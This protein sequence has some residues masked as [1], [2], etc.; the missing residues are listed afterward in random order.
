MTKQFSHTN[1]ETDIRKEDEEKGSAQQSGLYSLLIMVGPLSGQE[2]L[3]TP[4]RYTLFFGL[5]HDDQ[6][7]IDSPHNELVTIPLYI[8]VQSEGVPL[9]IDLDLTAIKDNNFSYCVRTNS[10]NLLSMESAKINSIISYNALT[11]FAIKHSTE[12]W[13]EKITRLCT[14]LG[15]TRQSAKKPAIKKALFAIIFLFIAILSAYGYLVSSDNS[16]KAVDG[17]KSIESEKQQER[18][19]EQ[20]LNITLPT[21]NDSCAL[22][23]NKIW[24]TL[25]KDEEGHISHSEAEKIV[26][27]AKSQGLIHLFANIVSQQSLVVNYVYRDA[28]NIQALEKTISSILPSQC[29]ATFNGYSHRKLINDISKRLPEDIEG[30]SF[31]LTYSAMVINIAEGTDRSGFKDL[32]KYIKQNTSRWGNDFIKIIE[33]STNPMFIDKTYFKTKENGG[34]IF[35]TDSHRYFLKENKFY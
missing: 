31:R 23:I 30:I 34:Y 8:P 21:Q 35:L 15:T 32:N 28:S 11:F 18:E 24:Q 17:I 1:N 4:R 3:L 10:N 6:S 2:L 26:D 33:I 22:A 14:E 29:Q 16:D 9:V 20:E 27:A 13:S 12:L 5:S 7:A 19:Q 25:H